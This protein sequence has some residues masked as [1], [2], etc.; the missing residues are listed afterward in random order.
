M[1]RGIVGLVLAC[2]TI[3]TVVNGAE[4]RFVDAARVVSIEEVTKTIEVRKPAESCWQEQVPLQRDNSDSATSEI[5]GGILGGVVGNQFG[6]GAG[7]T[8]MTGAGALLGG[9]LGHDYDNQSTVV[10]YKTVERCKTNYAVESKV[11]TDS[12]RVVLDYNGKEMV[13]VMQDR[14]SGE[15]V[16]IYVTAST[17]NRIPVSMVERVKRTSFRDRSPPLHRRGP[18]HGW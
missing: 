16:D 7:K 17:E 14:P 2:S 12:Y 5:L 11:V 9:S 8:L 6:D 4:I 10:A 1:N 3:P 13:T 18:R 15:T